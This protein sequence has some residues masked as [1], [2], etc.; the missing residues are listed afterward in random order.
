M[1][2][3]IPEP[4]PE[5]P[6]ETPP[7]PPPRAGAATGAAAA[8]GWPAGK[9]AGSAKRTDETP[10]RVCPHRGCRSLREHKPSPAAVL[11]SQKPAT[12]E[13][14]PVNVTNRNLPRS[15]FK[16][17]PVQAIFQD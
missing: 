3:L 6:P 9:G 17:S 1:R 15:R 2:W 10:F 8:A 13:L 11:V 7:E 14:Y 16:G 5:P 12:G 4:P